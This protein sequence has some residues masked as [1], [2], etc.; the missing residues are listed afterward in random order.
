MLDPNLSIRINLMIDGNSLKDDHEENRGKYKKQMWCFP[1]DFA[2]EL[3]PSKM[4]DKNTQR[5]YFEDW[6]INEYRQTLVCYR[7]KRP[8]AGTCETVN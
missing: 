1:G 6:Q 5:R 3:E 2:A 4:R 7:C 8:C